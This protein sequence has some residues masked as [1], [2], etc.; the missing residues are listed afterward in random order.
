MI[1]GGAPEKGYSVIPFLHFK[2]SHHF[3]LQYVFGFVG[4][5]DFFHLFEL[6]IWEERDGIF[7]SP[8]I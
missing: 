5:L 1:P 2:F 7:I 6:R 8:V 3:S 4:T